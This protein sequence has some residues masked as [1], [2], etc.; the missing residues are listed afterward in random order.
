MTYKGH[1]NLGNILFM[2]H[3]IYGT[4]KFR[5]FGAAAS[6]SIPKYNYCTARA[7]IV[8]PAKFKFL[9]AGWAKGFHSYP[10]VCSVHPVVDNIHLT[11]QFVMSGGQA[12][13]C[14][15]IWV[16]VMFDSPRKI[17]KFQCKNNQNLVSCIVWLY[18]MLWYG[19]VR[20]PFQADT[21]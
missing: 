20:P 11:S 10:A 4:F 15:L 14:A 8:H 6:N 7:D 5:E 9:W 12:Q 19:S 21:L 3:H 17:F 2:F 1:L 13:H 18:F 16:L